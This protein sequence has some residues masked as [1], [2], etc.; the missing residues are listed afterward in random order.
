MAGHANT[1]HVVLESTVVA[2]SMAVPEPIFLAFAGSAQLPLDSHHGEWLNHKGLPVQTRDC[3]G[4]RGG[5]RKVL[6][7]QP[8]LIRGM[9]VR[10]HVFFS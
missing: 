3:L 9:H 7:L 10:R 1:L 6:A 8:E 5:G 4:Q 2:G